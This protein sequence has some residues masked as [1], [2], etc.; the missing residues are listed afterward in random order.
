MIE[1][2]N[3]DQD[4]TLF[5]IDGTLNLA[6]LLTKENDLGVQDVSSGSEWQEGKAWMKLCTDDMSL[7]KYSDLTVTTAIDDQVKAECFDQLLLDTPISTHTLFRLHPDTPCVSAAAVGRDTLSLII[8]PIYF[9]WYKT[10]RILKLVIKFT[11][12]IR[13]KLHQGYRN[14]SCH[15][16]N[17]EEITNWDAE[18]VLFRHETQ[19]VKK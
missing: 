16:C 6:D 18:Q 19:V 10:L 12:I 1:W 5:H 13:H 14:T 8:D 11:K 17:K 2:T 15:I 3:G 9:G 7:K 4:I